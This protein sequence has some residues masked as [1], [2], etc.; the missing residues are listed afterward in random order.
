[1]D[2]V[3]STPVISLSVIGDIG[4]DM[5]VIISDAIAD[6]VSVAQTD[7]VAAAVKAGALVGAVAG[8]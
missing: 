7:F 5:D 8:S 6:Q 3:G 1:M 4:E 2:T